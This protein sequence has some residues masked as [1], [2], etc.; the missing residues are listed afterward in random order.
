MFDASRTAIRRKPRP[1]DVVTIPQAAHIAPRKAKREARE[2]PV[3]SSPP[4]RG[5]IATAR[6][7]SV[8]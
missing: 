5:G 4:Q 2:L 8:A 6:H 1:D 7:P 3:V